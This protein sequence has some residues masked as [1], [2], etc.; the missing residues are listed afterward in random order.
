MNWYEKVVSW[1]AKIFSNQETLIA[2][3]FATE[4]KQD[5]LNVLI[6]EV[7]ANPTANTLLARLKAIEDKLTAGISLSGSNITQDPETGVK[8]VTST[9]AELFAGVAAL[10]GRN[11]LIVYNEGSGNVYWG[12]G[13]VTTTTGF[14]LLPG[15]S[16]VFSFKSDVDT[17]IFFVAEA[18]TLVRVGELA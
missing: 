14:P 7:Q 3:D 5:A 16:I 12:K 1:L 17:P 4:A 8:T 6:G 18:D 11:K 15:D 10:D 2:K 13:T 9:A